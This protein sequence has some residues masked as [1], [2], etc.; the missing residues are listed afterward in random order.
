MIASDSVTS[1]V[2]TGTLLMTHL[3]APEV[4]GEVAVASIIVMVFSWMT[5]WGFS[6]YSVVKGRGEAQA[7]VT[8]HC[9]VAHVVMGG[10]A[11]IV[12]ALVGGY[13][14]PW[15]SAP[16]AAALVPGMALAF[17]LKRVAAMP[18]K[19][20]IRDMHFRAASISMRS[21]SSRF[22]SRVNRRTPGSFAESG[23]TRP[24]RFPIPTRSGS[25]RYSKRGSD[26]LPSTKAARCSATFTGVT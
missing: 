15:F 21:S 2:V 22:L 4:I 26:A 10:G 23:S 18:E 14:T 11:M 5:N 3:V 9:T 13:L 17:V 24:R 7:E 12:A 8:W 6:T 25:G 20:L 16:E 19:V 1:I